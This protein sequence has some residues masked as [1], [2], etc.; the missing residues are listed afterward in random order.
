MEE[1]GVT[2][3]FHPWKLHL[4]SNTPYPG[5]VED[6]EVPVMIRDIGEEEPHEE[7]DVQEV[8][9]CRKVRDMIQ[10]K[11]IFNGEW[12]DWNSN[13]PWQPWTDFKHARDKVMEYH[14]K[15]PRKP[16]PPDYLTTD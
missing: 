16:R 12:D 8:V 10:Y 7:W 4:A 6:P 1:A 3:V 2:P 5:Q 13:P 11:A 15:D 14:Q 9:N